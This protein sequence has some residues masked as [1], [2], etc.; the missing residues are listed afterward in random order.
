MK[1]LIEWYGQSIHLH[2]I[3]CIANSPWQAPVLRSVW[4][5]DRASGPFLL[6]CISLRHVLHRCHTLQT[7]P[8]FRTKNSK[9]LQNRVN[10]I[11]DSTVF[12][13]LHFFYKNFAS[14]F[15][16]LSPSSCPPAS[17]MDLLVLP[18]SH[19][20]ARVAQPLFWSG[21]VD[22]LPIPVLVPQ[23]GTGA[24]LDSTFFVKISNV[25]LKWSIITSV[26]HPDSK[27]FFSSP[28]VV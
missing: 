28:G 6:I 23:R 20:L 5:A 17:H 10:N 16:F 26:D 8:I 2:P 11:F 3:K 1:H 4:S 24:D 12:S 21:K 9:N 7:W 14:T 25:L 27:I 13:K 19:C 22:G 15:T 18:Y